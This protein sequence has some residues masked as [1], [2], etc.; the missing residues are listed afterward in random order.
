[1]PTVRC[2]EFHSTKHVCIAQKDNTK[3]TS[4]DLIDF[5]HHHAREQHLPSVGIAS[6]DVTILGEIQACTEIAAVAGIGSELGEF[7]VL[8]HDFVDAVVRQDRK[9]D[10]SN[11][12]S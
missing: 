8:L 5:A 3:R 11:K 4:S 9:L 10:R 7:E 1:M 12:A 2:P 6:R